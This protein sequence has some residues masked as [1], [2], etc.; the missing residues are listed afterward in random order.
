MDNT[1]QGNGRKR[2]AQDTFESGGS[3]ASRTDIVDLSQRN[4]THVESAHADASANGVSG[5]SDH[6]AKTMESSSSSDKDEFQSP[7]HVYARI[8]CYVLN[9]K[10]EE[11]VPYTSM[12]VNVIELPFVLGRPD[13]R[14]VSL[15]GEVVKHGPQT[16][17]K[18]L[19]ND[20]KVSLEQAVIDWNALE[21]CYQLY[22]LGK[23]NTW[24]NGKCRLVVC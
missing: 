7:C 11:M 5:S 6:G 4:G 12:T 20:K 8:I 23:A 21:K 9:D 1:H 15:E 16:V 2:P 24:V 17:N 10:I 22:V 14:A 13:G 19:L 3:K 18:M